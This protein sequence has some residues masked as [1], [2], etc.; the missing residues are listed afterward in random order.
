MRFGIILVVTITILLGAGASLSRCPTALSSCTRACWPCWRT[1]PSSPPYWATKSRTRPTATDTAAQQ[2][3]DAFG[4]ALQLDPTFALPW[5]DAGLVLYEV[6]QVNHAA[7]AF[8]RYLQLAPDAAE[9]P[10]IKAFLQSI[11]P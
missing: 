3:L 10:Q 9:A 2:A 11:R 5:R 7:K 6:R 1:R 4:N 8:D